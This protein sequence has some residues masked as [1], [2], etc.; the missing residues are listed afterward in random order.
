MA[1]WVVCTPAHMHAASHLLI[2]H[3]EPHLAH[4]D[5]EEH[6]G[7]PAGRLLVAP[8]RQAR[9]QQAMARAHAQAQPCASVQRLTLHNQK[10]RN[11]DA[12]THMAQ[13][14]ANAGSPPQRASPSVVV[15]AS[16]AF[17]SPFLSLPHRA[18]PAL[19]ERSRMMPLAS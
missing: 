12:Y 8:G 11:W 15:R 1:P 7:R 5:S 13:P 17:F 9:Q 3:D 16:P 19:V 6:G 10:D 18:S 14:A 4:R 2:A